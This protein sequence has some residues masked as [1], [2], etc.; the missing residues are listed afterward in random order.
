MKQIRIE[1]TIMKQKN[2]QKYTQHN[3][4]IRKKKKKLTFLFILHHVGLHY[5]ITIAKM[6]KKN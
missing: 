4:N 5:I 6:K 2:N 1:D 3:K